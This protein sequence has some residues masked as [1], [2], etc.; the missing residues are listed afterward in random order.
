MKELLPE[1]SSIIVWC[2]LLFIY[3]IYVIREL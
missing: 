1:K 2:I 3:A